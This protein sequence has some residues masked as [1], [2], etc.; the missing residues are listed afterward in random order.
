M[1]TDLALER[2]D[3]W[4]P[5]RREEDGEL[6]GYLV[7]SSDKYV[8][9]TVFGYVL[10]DPTDFEDAAEVLESVGMSYLAERWWLR[11]DDGWLA[12]EIVEASPDGVVV[13]S[14]DFG[15]DV[16]YGQRFRLDAPVA[17]GLL[18]MR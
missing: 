5:H 15:N 14:V 1:E 10:G 11:R 16:S 7:P 18:T 4:V 13:Q 2:T 12:V 8:P 3:A 17:D 9:V 6:L